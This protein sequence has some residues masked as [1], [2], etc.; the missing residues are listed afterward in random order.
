MNGEP[1]Q[2]TLE[3]K[4]LLVVLLRIWSATTCHPVTVTYIGYRIQ[5]ESIHI[6]NACLPVVLQSLVERDLVSASPSPYHPGCFLYV[7]NQHGRSR[8][9]A[10]HQSGHLTQNLPQ[11]SPLPESA[12]ATNKTIQSPYL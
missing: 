7:I 12:S 5:Q 8:V 9:V 10:W 1:Y 6:S 2:L 11:S 4:H 3:E